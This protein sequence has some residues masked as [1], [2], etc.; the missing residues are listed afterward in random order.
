MMKTEVIEGQW[1]VID[2]INGVSVYLHPELFSILDAI[3]DYGFEGITSIEVAY[4]Y[5]GRLSASG[6]LDCTEWQ[7]V[8]STADAC[9][10][11]LEELYEE[12]VGDEK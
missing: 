4:G 12:R 8:F 9:A 7:G 5:S 10:A 2:G 11:F 3:E 1:I 6:Y